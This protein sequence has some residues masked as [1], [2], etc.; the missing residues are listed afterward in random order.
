[1]IPGDHSGGRSQEPVLER[2]ER[3]T[4]AHVH[5]QEPDSALAAGDR[6]A[7]VAMR[8]YSLVPDLVAIVEAARKDRLIREDRFPAEAVSEANFLTRNQ[9]SLWHS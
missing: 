6:H 2:R 4:V 3:M 5:V 1:M 9:A 7:V 8:R